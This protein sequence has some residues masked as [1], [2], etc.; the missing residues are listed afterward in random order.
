MSWLGFTEFS[1][2]FTALSGIVSYFVRFLLKKKKVEKWLRFYCAFFRLYFLKNQMKKYNENGRLHPRFTR[3]FFS[4]FRKFFFQDLR[5][6]FYF[7]F[8]LKKWFPFFFSF[9]YF[10]LKKKRRKRRRVCRRRLTFPESV[11]T[12]VEEAKKFQKISKNRKKLPK[13]GAS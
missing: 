8:G 1:R 11:E 4:I 3:S 9:F 10:H 6:I 5:R 13:T 7:F 2:V 12:G